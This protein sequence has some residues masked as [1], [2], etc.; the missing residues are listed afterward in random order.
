M[1]FILAT[2]ALLVSTGIASA[3]ILCTRHNGCRETGI[4]LRNNGSPYVALPHK[5]REM[6][7]EQMEGKAPVQTRV[8][9]RIYY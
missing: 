4:K 3:D 8:L 5:P 9:R 2:I 6:T 1:K 7:K